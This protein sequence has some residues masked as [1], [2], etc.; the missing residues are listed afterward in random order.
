MLALPGTVFLP[1]GRKTMYV[2]AA[3]SLLPEAQVDEAL[4]RLRAVILAARA[5]L[6]PDSS[7]RS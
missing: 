2:R 4:A 3:F 5:E 7:G 1:S 6:D